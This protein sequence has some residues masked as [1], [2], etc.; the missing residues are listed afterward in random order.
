MSAA[1]GNHDGPLVSV[2]M[3][4]YNGEPWTAEAVESVLG[5]TFTDFELVV[6]DDGST[7]ATADVLRGYRDERLRVICQS[8]A[9]QTA[10]LNRALRLARAPL[11]ARMDADDVALP[12]RLERQMEFLAAHPEVGLLGTAGHE[13]A[14]TG[15][16]VRTLTPPTDDHAIRRT[17]IRR[18]PFIHTS[19]MFRRALLDTV[20]EYDES[21]SVAQDYDLWLRMSRR[22]RLATLA[23][24]LV[25][26]R[27]TPGQLSSAR[28]STRLRD[29]LMAK[30]RALRSGTYPPWCA[31]FLARPLCALALPLRLRRAIRRRFGGS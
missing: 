31:I 9:G 23:E 18:N 1:P 14:P 4:V 24:P 2:V 17:L 30:L 22:T 27:L 8:R 26:R 12:R 13:I 25:S 21:F 16:I 29:E 3:T 11:L 20:G 6:I 5:Q 28:D 15:K 19:V 10:A 7:D